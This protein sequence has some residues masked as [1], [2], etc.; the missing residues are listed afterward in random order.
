MVLGTHFYA[1]NRPGSLEVL[2]A[3]AVRRKVFLFVWRVAP[4]WSYQKDG[5]I[6]VGFEFERVGIIDYL[7]ML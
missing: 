2:L 1:L 6:P 7:S 4:L 3:V 5:D